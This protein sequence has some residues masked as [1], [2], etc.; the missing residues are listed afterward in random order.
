MQLN[1]VVEYLIKLSSLPD[2]DFLRNRKASL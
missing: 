1:Y 2:D